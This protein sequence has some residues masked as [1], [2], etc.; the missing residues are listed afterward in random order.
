MADGLTT[1]RDPHPWR[2]DM[3]ALGVPMSKQ[4]FLAFAIGLTPI[5]ALTVACDRKTDDGQRPV[6]QK[7][8]PLPYRQASA[9]EVFNLRSRCAELA[10]KMKT[11]DDHKPDVV[12]TARSHY[13]P[14]TNRCYVVLDKN[15]PLHDFVRNTEYLYDGQTKEQM[16]YFQYDDYMNPN[17]ILKS[18]T[19]FGTWSP[20]DPEERTLSQADQA[21]DYIIENMEDDH[22]N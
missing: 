22:N 2:H 21:R 12:V 11:D 5:L 3:Q 19:V 7:A 18:G 1:F 6:A 15:Y 13:N 9:S 17:K 10:E 4:K 14:K 20:S 8:E 16:A